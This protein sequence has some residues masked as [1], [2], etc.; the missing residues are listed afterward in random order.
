MQHTNIVLLQSDPKVAQKKIDGFTPEQR[1]FLGY[2]NIWCQNSTEQ[3]SRRLA[4]TDPHSPGQYRGVL[5][6]GAQAPD[7][8]FHVGRVDAEDL[9]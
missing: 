2:A 7:R 9:C 6:L 3:E 4:L 1:F 8:C 5:G